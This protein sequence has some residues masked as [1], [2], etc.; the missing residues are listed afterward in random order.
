[1]APA[2]ELAKAIAATEFVPRSFRNNPPAIAAA[3]LYG[4]EVG[5]GP[6]QSLALIAVIDGRP[7]M[8]AEAQRGLV[9]AAGHDL[10]VEHW[11]ATRCTWCGRRANRDEI[12]R[13][14]WTMDDARRAGISG[15]QNWRAYPR[16]MLSARASADLVRAVFADVVR[17]IGAIEEHDDEVDAEQRGV[18]PERADTKR[19]RRRAVAA[20]PDDRVSIV[21]PEAG[22]PPLPDENDAPAAPV[23][24]VSST[25]R[26][27]P[28][29]P[30]PVAMSTRSQRD[31][32]HGLMRRRG[33][34][35]RH[36]RLR[37]TT[38]VVGRVVTSSTE[39]TAAEADVLLD[40]LESTPAV[41]EGQGTLPVDGDAP[42]PEGA[43]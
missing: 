36:D 20:V 13:V 27:D 8:A 6:M 28:D 5:L 41:D 25:R 40:Y 21:A 1:M 2:V 24:P 33:I 22:L 14:E 42:E 35:D 43:E 15:K 26:D 29:D 38:A 18:T 9:L 37:L 17:G 10:W 31:R 12:T 19:R 11:T 7:F 32:M 16:Q 23:E 3:I 34:D 4:D 30:P 39:L